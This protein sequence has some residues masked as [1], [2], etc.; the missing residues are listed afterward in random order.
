[1][2]TQ[3]SKKAIWLRSLLLLPLM[4]LLLYSFSTKEILEIHKID[5][6]SIEEN[7]L[8]EAIEKDIEQEKTN[9]SRNQ[10]IPIEEILI[11]IN[12][13]GKLLVNAHIVKIEDLKS[14]LLKYNQGLTKEE[15]EQSVR[16]IIS[17]EK[18]TPN[19]IIKQVD[20]ILMHYG[21]ATIDI[22]GPTPSQTQVG[23][24]KSELQEFNTL[25]KKYNAQPQ[26][27]RVIPLKDLK[28][29]ETI[30]SSMTDEQKKNAQPFPECPLPPPPAPAPNSG[31]AIKL[32]PNPP[33]PKPSKT[34]IEEEEGLQNNNQVSK[35]VKA[36]L[37]RTKEP[38]AYYGNLYNLPQLPPQP[39]PNPVEYIKELAEKGATFYIGPH[40]YKTI[41][42][43]K[44]VRKSK[45]ARI[46]V[47]NYPIVKLGGC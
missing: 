26:E 19:N 40:Q 2:K 9:D 10:K 23:A 16:A 7:N 6:V 41:E 31:P 47:S 42:A 25:A 33:D 12:K 24:T 17:V 37:E 11:A 44:L 4:A 5:K 22:K 29:L 34:K 46:D 39:H 43:I 35:I 28:T 18:E 30:Y 3:T 20:A 32:S 14:H 1:M 15:R 8:Q 45:D 38:S 36:K 27:T 21:V 13:N